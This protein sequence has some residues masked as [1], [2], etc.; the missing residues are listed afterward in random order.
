MECDN[1]DGDLWDVTKTIQIESELQKRNT[2]NHLQIESFGNLR[3]PKSTPTSLQTQ[4][5]KVTH[6]HSHSFTLNIY[7]HIT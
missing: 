5:I 7:E 2:T 1:E 6:T 3:F 4:M